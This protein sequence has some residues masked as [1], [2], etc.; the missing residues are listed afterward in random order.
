VNNPVKSLVQT[1][2]RAIRP[3]LSLLV[4]GFLACGSRGGTDAAAEGSANGGSGETPAQVPAMPADEPRPPA[5]RAWVIFGSDT[6]VVEVARSP[7]ERA[8]GL[9]Y[10]EEVPDGTGM[11]FVF[12]DTGIRSFWMNNTY[13]ALD[14]AYMDAGFTI[15]DIQQMDPETTTPHESAVPAMFA[16]EV[17][18]GWFDERGIRTGDRAEVVFGLQVGG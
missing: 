3:A 13:V 10:R 12:P 7:D 1:P 17:R 2:I 4:V 6:V 16:L 11:L 15:V 18:Q 14:I 9:M 8:E 5:D